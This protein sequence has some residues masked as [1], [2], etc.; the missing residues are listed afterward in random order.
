M[1]DA[2]RAQNPPD[3]TTAAALDTLLGAVDPEAARKAGLLAKLM[4]QVAPDA[5]TRADAVVQ[6][7]ET[8]A[9]HDVGMVEV[10]FNRAMD[11]ER[12]AA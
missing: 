10:W 1:A 11:R 8:S 12:P 3:A 7:L 4:Q 6:Q 2:L 9:Q 5:T